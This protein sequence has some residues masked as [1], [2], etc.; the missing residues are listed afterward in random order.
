MDNRSKASTSTLQRWANRQAAAC[1]LD[2]YAGDWGQENAVGRV[3]SD[4]WE[5]VVSVKA[6]GLADEQPEE[7]TEATPAGLSAVEAAVLRVVSDRR[8]MTQRQI[9]DATQANGQRGY[10]DSDYLEKAIRRLW[11]THKLLVKHADGW[12]KFRPHV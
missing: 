5:V 9:A 8:P 11:L 10:D 3:A 12:I 4:A 7:R 1:H 2:L 6:I